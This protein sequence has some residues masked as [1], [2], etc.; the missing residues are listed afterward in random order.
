MRSNLE[1]F[2]LLPLHQRIRSNP[3]FLFCI[4]RETYI[5]YLRPVKNIVHAESILNGTISLVKFI[6][7][8][9]YLWHYV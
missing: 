5:Y 7:S 8:Y 1:L 4:I 2:V 6:D 9:R 3:V